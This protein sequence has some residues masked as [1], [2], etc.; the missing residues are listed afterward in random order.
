ML[1]QEWI[2]FAYY[3][4][5][6]KLK[7]TYGSLKWGQML[8][9]LLALPPLWLPSMCNSDTWKKNR[10]L[11]AMEALQVSQNSGLSCACYDEYVELSQ[12]QEPVSSDHLFRVLKAQLRERGY[13]T[14]LMK[15]TL[16]TLSEHQNMA[17]NWK[18]KIKG[19]Q[20]QKQPFQIQVQTFSFVC[21]SV[22]WS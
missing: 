8:G 1:Y 6:N 17:T 10:R 19:H 2:L 4:K 15:C 18:S 11:F 9:S 12:R 7:T 16:H 3:E 21:V 13:W 5:H 22:E 20:N 14:P